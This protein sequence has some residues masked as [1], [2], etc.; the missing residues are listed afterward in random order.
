LQVTFL[1]LERQLP[2][3]D[4]LFVELGQDMFHL[5]PPPAGVERA[6]ALPAASAD[7]AR[8]AWWD[9]LKPDANPT[10]HHTWL[11]VEIARY[12]LK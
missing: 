6:D 9:R 3:G 1:L 4:A 11:T 12:Y 2:Y 7:T 8:P 5:V 10:L